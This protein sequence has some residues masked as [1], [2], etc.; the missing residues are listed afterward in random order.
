MQF[1]RGSNGYDVTTNGSLGLLAVSASVN[2]SETVT[3]VPLGNNRIRVTVDSSNAVSEVNESDNVTTLDIVIPPPDPGINITA[4]RTQVRSG[5][6]VTLTW[7]ATLVYPMNCRVFGPG[8]NVNPSGLNGTQG[9]QPITA[10][11]EFTLSCTEPVTGTVFTD[12]V[13]VEA[14]GEIE[15]T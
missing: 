11:S 4:N 1:D 6:T 9:T 5:E 10:K 2:R 13:V 15:E 8:V 12:S 14:Q 7:T 3:N